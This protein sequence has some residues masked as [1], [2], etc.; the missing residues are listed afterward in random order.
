MPITLEQSKVGMA[1]KMEQ[2]VIDL[3]R[4]ESMLLD[5]LQF[6]NAVSPGTGGSTLTY[7]Y[8]QLKTP[9]TAKFRK[10]NEE[11]T[12]NE[13][14]RETKT[15]ELKVFGGK[16]GVDRVIASTSGAIDEVAFQMQQKIKGAVNLFNYA[17]IKGHANST[18]DGSAPEFDGLDAL[19]EGT[20]TE[21]NPTTAIDLSTSALMTENAELFA[22]TLDEWLSLFEERPDFLIMNNKMATKMKSVARKLGYY[23]R[24]EDAFGRGVDNYD[25]IP[26]YVVGTF[27][28]ETTKKAEEIVDINTGKETSIYGV[29]MDL[30]GFHGISPVGDKIFKTYKKDVTETGVIIDGEVEGVMGVV[31][32]NSRKAGVLRKIKIA[33]SAQ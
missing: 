11:Y 6:D 9:S 16:F 32:K 13:A 30:S 22:D 27:Y 5:R 29:K 3:L 26:F 23:S 12:A 33:P 19:L 24:T 2:T 28:N 21:Y 20:E 10:L 7:G 4:R 8:Q 18:K 1:D 17:L 15:A 14:I 31:L 25:G